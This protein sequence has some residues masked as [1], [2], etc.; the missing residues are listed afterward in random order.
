MDLGRVGA[1]RPLTFAGIVLVEGTEGVA[2]VRGGVFV[3]KV[4]GRRRCR[5]YIAWISSSEKPALVSAFDQFDG[6]PASPSSIGS[7]CRSC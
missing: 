5:E 1:D 2:G 4:D 7:T 3:E 6:R